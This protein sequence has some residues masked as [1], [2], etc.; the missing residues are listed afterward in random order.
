MGFN[1]AVRCDSSD[2]AAMGT[3]MLATSVT[4]RAGRRFLA[5]G[6]AALALA[7]ACGGGDAS[8]PQASPAS[9]DGQDGGDLSAILATTDLGVGPNRVSFLLTTSRSLVTVPQARVE[10]YYRGDGTSPGPVRESMQAVFHPW[11]YGT[12]GNYVANFNLDD[13][14]RW[15]LRVSVEEDGETLTAVI[16]LQVEEASSTPGLGTLP[17]LTPNRTVREA[18]DP[19]AL[20]SSSTPDLDLYQHSIAEI[21]HNGRP[22]MVVFASPA[23]CTTPTC[24]PQVETV[25]GIKEQYQ[26]DVDFVHVEVYDN[27][28]DIQGDLGRAEYAPA[29]HTWGLTGIEDYLNESWVFIL[30]REGRVTRKY[31]GFASAQ[32]LVEGLVE[33]LQFARRFPG[34]LE[35]RMTPANWHP[36]RSRA[37]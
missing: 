33:V 8:T 5:V 3:A 35:Y 19:S 21:I 18:S 14:G 28:Q 10:S 7:L 1:G 25:E 22:A 24:G 9:T 29:V 20:T 2:P 4:G 34:A 12:R 15:E 13:P 11:P 6:L 31:E 30:D 16:S 37:S 26:S 27:P 17:P 23:F 36:E 32:E